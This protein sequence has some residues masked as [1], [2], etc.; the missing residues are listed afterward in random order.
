MPSRRGIAR[1][2]RNPLVVIPVVGVLLTAGWLEYSR[3]EDSLSRPRSGADLLEVG[4]TVGA[5]QVDGWRA[6]HS[7]DAE[8][9]LTHVRGRV[10]DR[11][12]QLRVNRW[13]SGDI[14][15]TSPRVPL[16]EER[17]YLFK[18]YVLN[19]VPF[20][21]LVRRFDRDGGQE[22]AQLS[23]YPVQQGTW[24]TVADAVGGSGA[25]GDPGDTVA[26][27][28]VF[29]LAVPGS[30]RVDGAYVEPAD[31]VVPDPPAP[32]GPDLLPPLDR[33]APYHAG[34]ST[35]DFSRG[36]GDSLRT[37]LGG[38][39]DGEGKW[40]YPPVP[41]QPARAYR[42]TAAYRS[43][44]P[45]DVVAEFQL[46]DGGRRF[47]NLETVPPAGDWTT[48]AEQF[49]APAGATT[50]VVTLVSHGNGSTEARD[51]GLVDVTRPGPLS[52]DRP[53]V[54]ITFD[55][56]WESTYDEGV[57]LLTERGMPATFYVN[58]ATIETPEHMTAAEL[59]K[60]DRTGHE[61]AAHSY[62]HVD[63]TAI[64][65]DRLDAQ[66]RKAAD[67]LTSAGLP[68]ADL[69]TPFGRSDPQVRWYA[70][71]DYQTVRG[72]DTGVNTRQNLDPLNLTTFYVD[73]TTTQQ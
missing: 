20:T 44:R 49:Q 36:D 43:E 54:S 3:G 62:Q 59:R 16:P 34:D 23:R 65:A 45:V 50:V 69:A 28:Y 47:Q 63:L 27:Q 33:W 25:T 48:V 29:R 68:P 17:T 24:S 4:R 58:P 40:Q 52:W 10:D 22:L 70:Q 46:A 18:A 31:D 6:A 61:I 21:L 37:R 15:L 5:D 30:L 41:V 8:A 12:L 51:H 42:F 73:R 60:L 64:G 72:T 7:G 32:A 26:V 9:A 1:R 66:L 53:L 11:A 19:D 38:Y 14:T 2:L 39:R 57:P 35:A 56:G 71:R 67:E 13:G 55:D